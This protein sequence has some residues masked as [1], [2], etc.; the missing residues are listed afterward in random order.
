MCYILRNPENICSIFRDRRTNDYHVERVDEKFVE[1]LY[2][3]LN[4]SS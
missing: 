4:K 2:I 1:Y 3:I